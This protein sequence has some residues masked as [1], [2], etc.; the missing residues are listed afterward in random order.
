LVGFFVLFFF[1]NLLSLQML[2]KPK[3]KI[4]FQAGRWTTSGPD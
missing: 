4:S 3:Y 1:P 2:V